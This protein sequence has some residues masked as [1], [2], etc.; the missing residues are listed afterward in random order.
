MKNPAE[1]IIEILEDSDISDAAYD[2]IIEQLD[3]LEQGWLRCQ[4]LERAELDSLGFIEEVA[5]H[6][7]ALK[8][9]IDRFQRGH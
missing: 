3:E 6:V 1:I 7:V 8:R 5:E 2:D 4:T 9:D